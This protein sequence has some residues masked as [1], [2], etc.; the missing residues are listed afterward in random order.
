MP[1]KSMRQRK[2][3]KVLSGKRMKGLISKVYLEWE[4]DIAAA[5]T[6]IKD[7]PDDKANSDL[8]AE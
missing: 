8:M 5:Q 1:T 4:R 6:L 2:T 7:G 3:T